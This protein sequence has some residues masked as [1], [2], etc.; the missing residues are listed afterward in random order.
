MDD[1]DVNLTRLFQCIF[2]YKQRMGR[3]KVKGIAVLL[4][5]YD[6]LKSRLEASGMDLMKPEERNMFMGRYFPATKAA[7]DYY[8]IENLVFIPVWVWAERDSQGRPRNYS[9]KSDVVEYRVR[10]NR[11]TERPYYSEPQY[12]ELI[13]WLQENFAH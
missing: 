3:Q 8:N 7:L 1:P 5:K 2:E 6:V 4:S 11:E 10:I 13:K 9:G 12:M